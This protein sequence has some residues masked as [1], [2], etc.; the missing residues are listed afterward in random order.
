MPELADG[1]YIQYSMAA[2]GEIR[3]QLVDSLSYRGSEIGIERAI[4]IGLV[5]SF[6]HHE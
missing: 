4:I 5:G 3:G 2:G 1:V 6:T